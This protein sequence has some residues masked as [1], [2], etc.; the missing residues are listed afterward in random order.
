M[1]TAENKANIGFIRLELAKAI[2]KA[3][4]KVAAA[5]ET[6]L[7]IPISYS[8]GSLFAATQYLEM[9]DG[10]PE[11]LLKLLQQHILSNASRSFGLSDSLLDDSVPKML[12]LEALI[13]IA[14]KRVNAEKET[15]LS[16]YIPDGEK[17]LHHLTYL[18]MRQQSPQRLKYLIKQ[19]II[20]IEPVEYPFKASATATAPKGSKAPKKVA[21]ATGAF[22]D[23][24][25]SK[26]P[27][28]IQ[29]YFQQESIGKFRQSE[30]QT[31]SQ[32]FPNFYIDKSSMQ[33]GPLQDCLQRDHESLS[34]SVPRSFQAIQNALIISILQGETN[35]YLWG[36]YTQLRS[37]AEH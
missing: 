22:C 24:V 15:D 30:C 13:S 33:R 29:G 20:D 28:S 18:K 8:A 3:M 1:T 27:K 16:K 23:E 2:K 11:E 14:M 10:Q 9:K 12:E 4:K 19:S 26:D 5:K 6:D 37:R 17:R 25:I 32:T 35:H 31:P 21:Y 7:C 36:A 34:H